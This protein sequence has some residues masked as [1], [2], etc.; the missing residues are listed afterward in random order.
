[1]ENGKV[2]PPERRDAREAMLAK[3]RPKRKNALG[4]SAS[5]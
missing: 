2:L 3:G 5:P 4:V 1:M